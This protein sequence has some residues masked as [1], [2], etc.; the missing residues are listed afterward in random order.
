MAG[1][2]VND[3]SGQNLMPSTS[4]THGFV[5]WE[6]IGQKVCLA[7]TLGGLSQRPGFLLSTVASGRLEFFM[8]NVMPSLRSARVNERCL[9]RNCIA[10]EDLPVKVTSFLPPFIN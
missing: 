7:V 5:T 8:L 6:G 3:S 1:K 2:V 4:F 9:G 10:F